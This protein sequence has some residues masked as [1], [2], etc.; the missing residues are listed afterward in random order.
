MWWLLLLL[1]GAAILACYVRWHALATR[2]RWRHEHAVRSARWAREEPDESEESEE[3]Q[4]SEEQ[5]PEEGT[6]G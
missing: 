5:E 1:P 3:N 6:A 4:Q 2:A